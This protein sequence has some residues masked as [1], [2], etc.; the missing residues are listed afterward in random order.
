MS[1]GVEALAGALA[2]DRAAVAEGQWWRLA[3]ALLSHW[4]AAHAA[5]NALAIAILATAIARRDG[6]RLLLILLGVAIVAQMAALAWL[7]DA[8]QYRGSSGLAW[9][10]GTFAVA[11][12]LEGDRRVQW[13][14]AVFLSAVAVAWASAASASPVLPAAVLPDPAMHLAGVLAGFACARAQA[15]RARVSISS[16]LRFT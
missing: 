16:L 2:F 14:A 13:A 1:A 4:S 12:T 9:A 6:A 7:S 10:L 8:V 11:R 3:T 15:P 5:A